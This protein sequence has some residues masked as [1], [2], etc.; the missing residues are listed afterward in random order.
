MKSSSKAIRWALKRSLKWGLEGAMTFSGL[1]RAYSG[2]ERF[3][4][5][6][7][8]L[9]YHRILDDP[10]DSFTVTGRDFEDHMNYLRD[11]H[12]VMDL[13]EASKILS[14]RASFEPSSV[15]ITFDDGYQEYSRFVG[16]TLSKLNLTATFFIITGIADMEME[17]RSGTYMDWKEIKE[18][19]ESGF[20]I[21]SHT[22]SHR[23]LGS[24]DL[25][26]A[27]RELQNSLERIRSE[28]NTQEVGLSYPYGTM[29]DFNS[30][31]ASKAESSGYSYAVSA[32]NGMNGAGSDIYRLRRTSLT[33]GDGLGTFK[34]I[35]RGAL[36]PWV[37]V[38]R[39][40][41]MFQRPYETGLG[42]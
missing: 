14:S 22:M 42:Q 8:I 32:I 4:R 16:P 21:G 19:Q 38:D 13:L 30:L 3:R 18:L 37:L 20:S 24:L 25:D 5:G 6:L 7:R 41:Y 36:D 17:N 11:N 33:R 39:L 34:M 28:L 29:R 1:S 15:C 23:S 35:M 27:H 31:I 26:E 9:T 12:N 2:T 40:G 10:G